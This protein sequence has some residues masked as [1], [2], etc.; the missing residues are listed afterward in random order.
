MKVYS[1]R[2]FFIV[3]KSLELTTLNTK[4][5]QQIS[6][7]KKISHPSD[8]INRFLFSIFFGSNEQRFGVLIL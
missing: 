5:N 4:S 2:D 6:T 7:F 8:S 1:Y 3:K